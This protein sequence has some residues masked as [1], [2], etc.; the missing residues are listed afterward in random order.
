MVG[1]KRVRPGHFFLPLLSIWLL[2]ACATGQFSMANRIHDQY[3]INDGIVPDRRVVRFYAPYKEQIDGEMDR[4]I[5]QSAVPLTRSGLGGESVMGNFFADALYQAGCR[6]DPEVAFSFGTK[7]G[8]RCDLPEGK[9]TVRNLYELMPF[10][11]HLVILEL[12]GEQIGRLAQFIAGS[13]GQPIAG[14]EIRIRKG[15]AVGLRIDGEPVDP[16]DT[17]KMVTYDYLANGGDQVPGLENPLSRVDLSRGVRDVMIDYI[18]EASAAN[19]PI[20]PKLDGRIRT[21]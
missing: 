15:K 6:H 8:L 19:E 18:K 17:Y 14:M 2:T 20:N 21:N 11:N 5:G 3:E 4:V 1:I 9:L 13:G 12:S 10:E 7:G 16:Q